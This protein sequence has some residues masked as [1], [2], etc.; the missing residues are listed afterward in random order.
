MFIN[1]D[2]VSLN[3][4]T[5]IVYKIPVTIIKLVN[6]FFGGWRFTERQYLFT[7][8]GLT[9]LGIREVEALNEALLMKQAWTVHANPNSLLAKGIE[10]R[11]RLSPL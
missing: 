7:P 9:G 6:F 10:R 5:F 3:Q 1:V 2:L 8:K 4:H 11:T